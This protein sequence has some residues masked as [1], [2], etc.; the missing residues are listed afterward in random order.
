MTITNLLD[1]ALPYTAADHRC[2]LKKKN[3]TEKRMKL[4]ALLNDLRNKRQHVDLK[5]IQIMA[6]FAIFEQ[7]VNE[8]IGSLKQS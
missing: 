1:I 4:A 3:K 8:W 7:K 6:D 5:S 2:G